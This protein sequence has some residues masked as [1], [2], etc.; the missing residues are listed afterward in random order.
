M[1]KQL[2]SRFIGDA[3]KKYYTAIGDTYPVKERLKLSEGLW[4]NGRWELKELPNRPIEGITYEVNII[5]EN[6]VEIPIAVEILRKEYIKDID[7]SISDEERIVFL[8]NNFK[9]WSLNH[10]KFESLIGDKDYDNEIECEINK[11]IASDYFW[12]EKWTK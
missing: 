8:R 9:N 10:I 2:I 4:I 5:V 11:V 6:K 12:K 1:A 7:L 3:M